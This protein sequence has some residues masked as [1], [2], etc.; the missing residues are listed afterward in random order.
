[1]L[2]A[3][4]ICHNFAVWSFTERTGESK[5]RKW[6][7][8]IR[9]RGCVSL[10]CQFVISFCNFAEDRL[11]Y[12]LSHAIMTDIFGA[13]WTVRIQVSQWG[14][15]IWLEHS[16]YIHIFC[17]THWFWKRAAKSQ[18]SLRGCAGWSGPSLSAYAPTTPFHVARH[19]YILRKIILF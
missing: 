18:I 14:C 17:S 2:Y 3:K 16:T 12:Y 10:C 11:I 7:L 9:E 5:Q 15:T 8:L 1:M 13:L 19:L 6:K 4:S